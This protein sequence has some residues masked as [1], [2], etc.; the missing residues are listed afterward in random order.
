MLF[1]RKIDPGIFRSACI[2][3]KYA[4]QCKHCNNNFNLSVGKFANHVR[5]CDK[6]PKVE[7]YRLKNSERAIALGNVRFGEYSKF[8]VTCKNCNIKF[9]VKERQ[10]L[11]PSKIEY[12]C[13]RKCANATGGK[14]KSAKYH[15]DEDAHYATVAWRHHVKECVICGENLVVAVHHFDENH[16]NND[17]KNLVPLCPTHHTYIH[18]R[19]KY[20]IEDKVNEYVKNKW[21]MGL[22]G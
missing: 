8:E 4:M 21:G 17:P 10:N 2:S 13:T 9:L 5:W 14:A 12:F 16:D 22:L 15:S 1:V 7:E 19:H 20:L 6:N 11:F 3:H 18:S